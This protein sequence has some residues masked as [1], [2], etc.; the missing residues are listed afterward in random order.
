MAANSDESE[1]SWC[2]DRDV[3]HETQA[4][5]SRK[6]TPDNVL[7]EKI[8][9]DSWYV[10]GVKNFPRCLICNPHN[11]ATMWFKNQNVNCKPPSILW[12]TVP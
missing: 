7:R 5:V 4:K 3:T 11:E 9:R 12:K 8:S 1:S 2:D 10:S 6:H